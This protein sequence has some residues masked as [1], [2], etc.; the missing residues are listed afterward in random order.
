MLRTSAPLIGALGVRSESQEAGS[1]TLEI[2]S[3]AALPE[4]IRCFAI[5]FIGEAL[6]RRDS[7]KKNKVSSVVGSAHRDE[8]PEFSK[9]P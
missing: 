2:D 3:I 7:T 5:R 6:W 8:K 9:L 1:A 4:R